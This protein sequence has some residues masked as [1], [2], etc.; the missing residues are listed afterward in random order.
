MVY[1][2]WPFFFMAVVLCFFRLWLF[3]IKVLKPNWDQIPLANRI[4]SG[5]LKKISNLLIFSD[6]VVLLCC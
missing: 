4:K 1:L 3:R 5:I 6:S 2:W